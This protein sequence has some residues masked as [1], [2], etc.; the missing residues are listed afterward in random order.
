MDVQYLPPHGGDPPLLS[1][2]ELRVAFAQPVAFPSLTNLAKQKKEV[3]IIFDD[4]SQ[5]TKIDLLIP[6]IFGG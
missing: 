6:Y 3:C 4:M 2:N 5:P 1:A